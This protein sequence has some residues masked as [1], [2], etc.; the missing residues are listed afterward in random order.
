MNGEEEYEVVYTT[1]AYRAHARPRRLAGRWHGRRDER[2]RRP[3]GRVHE[4]SVPRPYGT[5]TDDLVEAVRLV[6]PPPMEAPLAA[7][8]VLCGDRS[9]VYCMRG[10]L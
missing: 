2:S 4:P 3:V 8:L 10:R 9:E 1:R 7:A 5:T 6:A